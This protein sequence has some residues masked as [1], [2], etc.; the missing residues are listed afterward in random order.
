MAWKIVGRDRSQRDDQS[1][2]EIKIT[3][4]HQVGV[5]EQDR[6]K[7]A[8]ICP[9][10]K[11]EYRKMP[12]FQR[13]MDVVL[14]A[15]IWEVKALGHVVGGGEVSLPKAR[16]KAM[17]EHQKPKTK[18]QLWNSLGMMNFYRRFI[19][20]YHQWSFQLTPST[21]KS[22][23]ITVEWTSQMSEAFQTLKD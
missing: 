17:K 15:Q 13:L 11:F 19:P 9:F 14:S 21:S 2:R 18:K 6:E 8:F 12:L 5:R 22:A 4:F 16:M 20:G 10:G 1:H 23:A 3:N 7:T